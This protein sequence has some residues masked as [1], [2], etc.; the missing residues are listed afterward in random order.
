MEGPNNSLVF[1]NYADSIYRKLNKIVF[2][3]SIIVT[4]DKDFQTSSAPGHSKL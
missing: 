4:R 3:E 2:L 1:Y